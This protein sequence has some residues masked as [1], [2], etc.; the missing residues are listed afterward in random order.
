MSDYR[1]IVAHYEQCLA[2]HGDNHRGVDWPNAADAQKRYQVM[3][4]VIRPNGP[5]NPSVLDFGCGA[6]HLLEY[7]LIT[8]QPLAYSG[9]DLSPQFISLSKAKFPQ[10]PYYCLDILEKSADWPHFDYIIANG[11]FNE[12]R[13]LSQQAMEQY[14]TAMLAE[15]FAHTKV[16]LAFNV[17]STLVDW[18][19]ADLFHVPFDAMARMLKAHASRDFV[20]R[21][22]YGLYEYTVYV[23]RRQEAPEL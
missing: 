1:S 2:Q 11:V 22:D 19:R 9:L 4:D 21:Q 13:E 10:L 23:Y 16:G 3:L 6:S 15:L 8:E 7:A 14:F 5:A 18:E 17:M 20:I 12:K